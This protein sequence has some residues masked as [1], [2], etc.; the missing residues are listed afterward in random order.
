[1]LIVYRGFVHLHR[2]PRDAIP[3]AD[4]TTTDLPVVFCPH[5]G[6]LNAK[7]II[8]KDD[9]VLR[10]CESCEFTFTLNELKTRPALGRIPVATGN[11]IY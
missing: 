6:E 3:L 4:M 9:G 2:A 1:M 10:I 11:R 7:L 8:I 5:C